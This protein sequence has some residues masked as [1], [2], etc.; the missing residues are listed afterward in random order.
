MAELVRGSL[1]SEYTYKGKEDDHVQ[2]MKNIEETSHSGKE[3]TFRV[4]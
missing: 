1:G 2:S 3:R 4:V